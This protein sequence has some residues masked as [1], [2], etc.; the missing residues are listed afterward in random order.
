MPKQALIV[1]DIQNDYFDGGNY[2][3]WNTEDTLSKI[4]NAVAKAQLKSIPIILVQHVADVSRGTA[5]FFNKGTTGVD[6]HPRILA[7][8]PQAEVVVKAFADSFYHTD[9]E[10]VLSARDIEELLICGMMTQNCVAFTAVSKA[11]EK[12]SIKVLSDCC[13]SVSQMVHWIAL[14]ALSIRVPLVDSSA[15]LQ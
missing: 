4:E 9:L 7:A 2:P 15:E 5:P 10:S 11:A 12:Y 1:I 3:Q 8:A 6:I 13:T 14:N